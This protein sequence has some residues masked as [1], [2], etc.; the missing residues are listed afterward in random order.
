V[1]GEEEGVEGEKREE[2]EAGVFVG[3]YVGMGG[4]GKLDGGEVGKEE[5]IEEGKCETLDD[6]GGKEGFS[7]N[8]DDVDAG[9]DD[10]D[11]ENDFLK[12]VNVDDELM[13]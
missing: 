3:G 5:G 11:D 1:G 9:A 7:E 6:K 2:W 4:I 12:T 13:E 8:V 10:D